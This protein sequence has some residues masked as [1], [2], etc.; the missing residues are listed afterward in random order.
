MPVVNELLWGAVLCAK[1][2]APVSMGSKFAGAFPIW[3]EPATTYVWRP[4]EGAL[5]V[6]LAGGVKTLVE[7]GV[8]YPP[9]RACNRLASATCGP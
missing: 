4:L 1:L 8:A 6:T 2:R 9:D 7:T 3:V 5:P